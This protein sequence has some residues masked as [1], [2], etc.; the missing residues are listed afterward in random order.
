[1]FGSAASRRG[2]RRYNVLKADAQ[3][4]YISGGALVRSYSLPTGSF[5][6]D[7]GTRPLQYITNGSTSGYTITAPANDG[8]CVVLVTNSSLA[9]AT[10]FSGFTVGSNTGDALTTTNASKF[11]IYINR[12]NG[13][14]SYTIQALQ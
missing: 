11:K 2:L 7:T 13:V 4:Q 1:M 8:S 9:G 10:T 6:V 3:D 5:T 12:I 14:S